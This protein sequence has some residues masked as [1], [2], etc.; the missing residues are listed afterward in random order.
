MT[1]N[2][3]VEKESYTKIILAYLKQ[4]RLTQEE[5]RERTGLSKG[6]ISQAITQLL[7]ANLIK[8]SETKEQMKNVYVNQALEYLPL[9][10]IFVLITNYNRWKVIFKNDF[11]VLMQKESEWK[12]LPGYRD[13]L[14]TL[15]ILFENEAK[16]SQI[17]QKANEHYSMN[18]TLQQIYD[19]YFKNRKK[20][21][22]Y[23]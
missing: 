1:K 13:I 6:L 10:A 22:T 11:D 9:H 3:D 17:E 12:D 20:S 8:I 7:D 16:Y 18:I 5:L 2:F 14:E 21:E 23:F 19:R 15:K 4:N